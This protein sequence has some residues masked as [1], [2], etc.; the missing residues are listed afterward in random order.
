MQKED[1]EE[2]RQILTDVLAGHM[3]KQDGQYENLNLKIDNLDYKVEQIQI[4]TTK[5][6]GRVTA[7]ETKPHTMDNC[8][9]ASVI[10]ALSDDV[11][12]IKTERK[13]TIKV[14][15]FVAAAITALTSFLKFFVFT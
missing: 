14:A 3:A 2:V 11:T 4:Q 12:K 7:L 9:Q 6:N 5:T 8:K 13:F 10:D 15:A 1:R